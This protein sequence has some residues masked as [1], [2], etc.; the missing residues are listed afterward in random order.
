M[1]YILSEEEMNRGHNLIRSWITEKYSIEDVYMEV[2]KLQQQGYYTC[3]V[4]NED[5]TFSI[6]MFTICD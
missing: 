4:N 1:Q 2:E 3:I 5:E 6:E